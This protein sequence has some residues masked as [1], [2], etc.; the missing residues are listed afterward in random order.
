M[1]KDH[2]IIEIFERVLKDPQVLEAAKLDPNAFSRYRKMSFF[3]IACFLFDLD[4]TALQN[5]LN[6]FFNYTDKGISMSQQSLSEARAKFDHTP[7]EKLFRALVIAAYCTG[8]ERKTWNGYHIYSV[9]TMRFDLPG[10]KEL[11]EYFGTFGSD[12]SVTGGGSVVYDVL[13]HYVLDSI[14]TKP[15][16]SDREELFNH[17]NNM[18]AHYPDIFDQSILLG[19][20]GYPGESVFIELIKK[21]INFV[22]RC[23]DIALSAIVEAPIGSSIITIGEGY[24]LRVVK[25]YRSDEVIT[26]ATNLFYLPYDCFSELYSMRWGV[27]TSFDICKNKLCFESF[28][29]RTVNTIKQ[30]FWVAMVLMNVIAAYRNIANKIIKEKESKDKELVKYGLKK[31]ANKHLYQVA[32]GKLL[33]TLRNQ[34]LFVSLCLK[35]WKRMFN[36]PKIIADIVR[37]VTA[38]IPGRSFPIKDSI[39][40]RTVYNRKSCL[41]S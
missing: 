5:R 26:L 32:I 23:S 31:K 39:K 11:L 12:K 40:K 37:M 24:K 36:Q 19:D 22:I 13:N 20:R 29:G 38:I 34:Y 15:N 2:E 30:D 17:L 6:D 41:C 14:I 35:P 7:F 1:L 16:L 3:E 33:I 25:C 21:G 8:R 10:R 18:Q 4:K 28:S 27:E 9:D